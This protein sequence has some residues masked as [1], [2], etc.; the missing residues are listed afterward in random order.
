M[1]PKNRFAK[2]ENAPAPASQPAPTPPPEDPIDLAIRTRTNAGLPPE[3]HAEFRAILQAFVS[4]EAGN[5]EAARA[6]LQTIG[7]K[8]P[9]QDWKL[10]IRG[11]MAYAIGDDA[12]AVENW[13]RLTTGRLPARLA[14]LRPQLQ[15]IGV[16]DEEAFPVV[17]VKSG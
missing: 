15:A 14:A 16:S 7:L 5:D 2:R 4:Y 8:S 1:A 6:A 13:Q 3:H 10:L 9:F 11:L 17:G 12:R